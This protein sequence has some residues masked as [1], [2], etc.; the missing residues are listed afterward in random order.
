MLTLD[1]RLDHDEEHIAAKLIEGEA[2]MIDLAN[3]TYYSLD[4]AGGTVWVLI[5]ARHSLHEVAVALA[6]RY[7][8][9]LV[10]AQADVQ[11]LAEQLV[12]EDLVRLSSDTTP[13][14]SID[15][16]ADLPAAGAKLPYEPLKLSIYRDMEDLLALD[17]PM[18]GLQDIPWKDSEEE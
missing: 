14:L 16:L 2:V 12:S 7:Q 3:G 4:K 6:E 9:S 8:V 1:S 11:C 10:Q 15:A 17:P 18:P 5:A 13:R